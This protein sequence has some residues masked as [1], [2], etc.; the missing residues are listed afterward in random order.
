M[1]PR[2]RRLQPSTDFDALLALMDAWPKSWAGI[3]KDEAVG[4]NLTNLM[5]PFFRHLRRHNF[6]AKTLRRH[7]DNLWIL[8]GE[9]IRQ[10]HDDTALRRR[11]S[12]TLLLDAVRDGD[13]IL[14]SDFAEEQQRSLD[15]TARKLFH[16]LSAS[17]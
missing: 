11:T 14:I 12:R 1:T 13:A 4:R 9:I 7:L 17:T 6:A 2:Q 8:G 10:L 5:R 3:P 16:F 15:A